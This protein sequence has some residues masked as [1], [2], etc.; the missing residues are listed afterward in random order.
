M[1]A[2]PPKADINRSSISPLRPDSR[3]WRRSATMLAPGTA[4]KPLEAFYRV[5]SVFDPKRTFA[6]RGGAP[7]TNPRCGVMIAALDRALLRVP[8]FDSPNTPRSLGR[9]GKAA[10][11]P[12]IFPGGFAVRAFPCK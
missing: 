1:S 6:A 8:R 7:D 3:R 5:M 4:P 12:R 2:L 11:L 10:G 9:Y